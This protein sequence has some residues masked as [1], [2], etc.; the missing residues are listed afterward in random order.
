V[1]LKNL[2]GVGPHL[3]VVGIALEGLTV[4]TRRWLSF[5]IP[6]TLPTQVIL[7]LP[8]VFLC[9][10]G[11]IWFNVSLNLVDVHLSNGK[12]ELLTD[13]PFAYV[14][15]PLYTTVLTTLPPL[16][17][18]WFTD[19]VFL[20]PWV[21]TVIAAHGIVSIEERGLGDVF[22]EDYV[23]YRKRVPALIPY[24]GAA[25]KRLRRSAEVKGAE[26]GNQR[27]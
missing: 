1:R 7:T 13:G 25:G 15:H 2:L 4:L 3:L 20:V 21:L 22:G 24:R 5:P 27:A 11:I 26:N 18:I 9:V 10:A 6:L 12:Q 19:L 16:F 14:R 8:C 23:N 17:V